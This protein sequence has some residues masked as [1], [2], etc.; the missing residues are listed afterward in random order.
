M[1]ALALRPAFVDVPETPEPPALRSHETVT[2]LEQRAWLSLRRRDVPSALQELEQA[3]ELGRRFSDRR[4]VARMS[5]LAADVAAQAGQKHLAR[6]YADEAD[7]V[8]QR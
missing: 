7:L 5:L 2:L 1:E 4:A 6:Y 8:L 3:M